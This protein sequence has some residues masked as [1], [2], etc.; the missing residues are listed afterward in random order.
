M[1][2]AKIAVI[3]TS[4]VGCIRD[5]LNNPSISIQMWSNAF[6]FAL[7]APMLS[8]QNHLGW[9]DSNGVLSCNIPE[10]RQL[11]GRLFGNPDL[12]FV[13][14]DYDIVLLVDFFYCY[15][16]A[17]QLRDNILGKITV[18]GIPVSSSLYRQLIASRLGK[19]WYGPTAPLGEIP[20]NSINPLLSE[21]KSAAPNTKFL[22]AARPAQ[23]A[24][25][26]S[27]LGIKIDREELLF[28][29]NL[30]ESA[31]SSSLNE[32]G[33][34]FVHRHTN[35]ICSLSGMTPDHFS[36]GSHKTIKGRL[37]EHTNSKYGQLILQQAQKLIDL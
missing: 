3:G 30:F 28:S 24:A 12:R 29:M 10:G 25:N 14:S 5:A 17:H 33:I 9:P 7:N 4:H 19:S 36:V 23:P 8:K 34:E 11:L 13:P 37:D 21:M 22:L 2:K 27:S 26:I 15:D 18:S 16:F 31:A 6:F 35:Q 20:I 1:S 32:I